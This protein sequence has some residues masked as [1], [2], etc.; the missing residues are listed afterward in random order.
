MI[1]E[2]IKFIELQELIKI[3][4]LS[5][6]RKRKGYKVRP[7]YRN[8]IEFYV[9]N[10]KVNNFN[11]FNTLFENYNIKL[12]NY[13]ISDLNN[14]IGFIA[15]NASKYKK[16]KFNLVDVYKNLHYMK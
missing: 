7:I 15:E 10:D 13:E 14:F 4:K 1:S 12:S 5:A 6:E 2:D 11:D 9:N 8:Q 16:L 3:I